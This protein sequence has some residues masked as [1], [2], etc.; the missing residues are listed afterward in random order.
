MF[1]DS[2]N[3]V[4]KEELVSVGTL[5]SSLIHPREVFKSAIKESANSVILVHNHPSGDC[6]PSKDDVEVSERLGKVG[7]VLEIE[8]V[9]HVI[10][11]DGFWSWKRGGW[12]E[13]KN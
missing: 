4:I 13:G 10:V 11:G 12:K 7:K 8:V 3:R 1:L 6:S 2:K 9:D 5:N